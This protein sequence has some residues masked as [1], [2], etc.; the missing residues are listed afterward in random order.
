MIIIVAI[1]LLSKTISPILFSRITAIALIYAGA[2]S[3]NA[4]YIQS[5]GSG[6]GIYSGLFH[7]TTISQLLDTFIFVIGSLILISWP[8]SLAGQTSNPSTKLNYSNKNNKNNIILLFGIISTS[9][10]IINY[11]LFNKSIKYL[12]S[13]PLYSFNFY[14]KFFSLFIF[15]VIIIF[16]L[17][18]EY[19]LIENSIQIDKSFFLSLLKSDSSEE[20]NTKPSLNTNLDEILCED[21]N[22]SSII[23]SFIDFDLFLESMSQL[24][25]IAFAGVLMN[26]LVLTN[27]IS[28]M[29]VL[30][31][32]YW[33][34]KLDLEKKYPRIYKIIALR[35][36]FQSYYLKVNFA[37]I[38][39]SVLPQMYVYTYI[40]YDKLIVYIN[41]ILQS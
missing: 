14:F 38:I 16:V 28:I 37:F 30:Y 24:G 39:A 25:K 4:F 8:S 15:I 41:M 11:P 10:S 23:P 29:V 36:K 32:D 5:I 12:S 26:Y 1:A 9:L 13:L 31:G 19:N 35:R 18:R 7:V 22:K 20:A 3:F 27:T 17:S 2:L 6:I 21:I 33:I 34:T 40:C